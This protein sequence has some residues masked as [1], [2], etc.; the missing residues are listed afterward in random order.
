M[1]TQYALPKNKKKVIEAALKEAVKVHCDYLDCKESVARQ[2]SDKSPRWILDHATKS[3]NFTHFVFIERQDLLWGGEKNWWDV[4][5]SFRHN[6][7]RDYFLFIELD[8]LKGFELVKK[9]KL[10]KYVF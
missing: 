9:F 1:R 10:E 8:Y 2:S 4:G 3:K 6:D 5:C 7:G